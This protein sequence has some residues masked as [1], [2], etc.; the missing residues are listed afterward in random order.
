MGLDLN[1][2]KTSIAGSESNGS[3]TARND[4]AGKLN[5]VKPGKWAW[6][7][8]QFTTDTLTRYGVELRIN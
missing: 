3:Y 5:N 1:T 8:Y 2:Y 6:G 4:K 7:K